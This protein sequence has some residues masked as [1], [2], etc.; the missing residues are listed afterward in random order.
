[1]LKHKHIVN[2]IEHGEGV[3]G[4]N[5]EPF[6]YILL[7]LANGGSLFDYVA[8]AGRFEEKFA[9]H[10]F[11]QLMEGIGFLHASG[12]AHRDIKPENLLLDDHF[13]LKIADFGFS[14]IIET[15]DTGKLEGKLGTAGYM[16]PEIHL[17]ESYSGS[18]VDL[19]A[20]GIVLFTLLTRRVPFTKAHPS[21]PHYY[22]L[23]TNPENFW[24]SHAEAEDGENIYSDEF[25]DLFEKMMSFNPAL[26][27]N[28]DD[29]LSHPWMMG[30]LPS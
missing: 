16:A 5:M 17:G 28:I 21:D 18:S 8:Q 19:Y 14:E 30:E 22:S 13:N 3:Q 20:A 6:Q 4:N 27:P 7:E 26:R 9:R 23:V 24:A 12:F 29:V 10:F 25:K 2:L 15:S 1:M 11:S